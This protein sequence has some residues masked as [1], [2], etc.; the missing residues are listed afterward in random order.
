MHDI[1]AR[2]L[3][4]FYQTAW[5]LRRVDKVV[6]HTL[7]LA[8]FMQEAGLGVESQHAG[9]L[10]SQVHGDPDHCLT[11]KEIQHIHSFE[12]LSKVWYGS[13]DDI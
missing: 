3:Q 9:R 1:C 6:E 8:R 10:L 11:C 7:H 2:G 5:S 13:A 4:I 12:D